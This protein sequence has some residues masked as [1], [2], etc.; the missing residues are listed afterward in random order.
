MSGSR[1]GIWEGRAERPPVSL[2]QL[3]SKWLHVF[4]DNPM[5]EHMSADERERRLFQAITSLQKERK[6]EIQRS[7]WFLVQGQHR[8]YT[9]QS[10]SDLTESKGE[11]LELDTEH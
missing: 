4:N 6:N 10:S 9:C 11:L 8:L 3:L 1:A 5:L 2:S 7:S